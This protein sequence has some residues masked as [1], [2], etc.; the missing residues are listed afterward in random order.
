MVHQESWPYVKTPSG[1]PDN[2]F[3]SVLE[4]PPPIPSPSSRFQ[5]PVTFSLFSTKHPLLSPPSSFNPQAPVTIVVV[6]KVTPLRDRV[7]KIDLEKNRSWML[8]SLSFRQ[9]QPLALSLLLIFSL[10]PMCLYFSSCL[11]LSL[12][13]SLSLFL[14]FCSSHSHTFDFISTNLWFFSAL[15]ILNSISFSIVS[16]CRYFSDL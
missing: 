5:P 3:M 9:H 8:C 13:F 4:S 7:V 2:P 12:P 6:A 11:Y 16:H 15:R 1:R 14:L 10:C